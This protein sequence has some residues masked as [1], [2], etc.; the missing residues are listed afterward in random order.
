MTTLSAPIR[1]LGRAVRD[2]AAI[3]SAAVDVPGKSAG[4]VRRGRRPPWP[5]QE[6]E[7]GGG[8]VREP[9]RPKPKPPTGAI[10][11]PEPSREPLDR[12][13]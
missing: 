10:A 11:L 4:H 7:G 13:R 8:G 5:P 1:R 3:T 6:D 2:L 12:G 9:R